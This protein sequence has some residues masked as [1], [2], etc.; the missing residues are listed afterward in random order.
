[1]NTLPRQAEKERSAIAE[2]EDKKQT[3]RYQGHKNRLPKICTTAKI[4]R[5]SQ[6]EGR[7]AGRES[8]MFSLFFVLRNMAW[9]FIYV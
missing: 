9:Q 8:N 5:D 3:D 7:R 1:M 4:E 6:A 2:L